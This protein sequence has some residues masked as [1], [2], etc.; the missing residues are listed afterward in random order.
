MLE[1]RV[2]Y[3]WRTVQT[4]RGVGKGIK[5]REEKLEGYW[6]SFWEADKGLGSGSAVDHSKNLPVNV[7]AIWLF[8]LSSFHFSLISYLSSIIFCLSSYEIWTAHNEFS[9]LACLNMFSTIQYSFWHVLTC[10]PQSSIL[11]DMS[12]SA[13]N[14][15]YPPFSCSCFLSKKKERT[16]DSW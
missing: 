16:M 12:F 9:F 10:Y 5:V 6:R 1:T 8:F 11:F 7:L 14:F 4:V 3:K 15:S 13:N 2:C